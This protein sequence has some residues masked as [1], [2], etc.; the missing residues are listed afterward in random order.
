MTSRI[1]DSHFDVEGY[2]LQALVT[3]AYGLDK[4]RIIGPDWRKRPCNSTV[5]AKLPVGASRE[6]LP[7]MMC[8]LL[9]ERFRL[10]VHNETREF[11]VYALMVGKNGPKLGR[12]DRMTMLLQ[13]WRRVRRP[14]VQTQIFR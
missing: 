13:I 10:A 14:R 5:S 1:D 3:R 9:A 4:Y 12:R 11:H 8:T 2:P 7:E 6:L